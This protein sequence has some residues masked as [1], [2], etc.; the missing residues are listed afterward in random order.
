MRHDGWGQNSVV[1]RKRPCK[2]YGG[3]MGK[4]MFR[5]TGGDH[6][7]SLDEALTSCLRAS[8][9][10][11]VGR[12]SK[13]APH[14]TLV[15]KARGKTN[16]A[17][18][19]GGVWHR[20]LTGDKNELLNTKQDRDPVADKQKRKKEKRAANGRIHRGDRGERLSEVSEAWNKARSM[21]EEGGWE[22]S[23]QRHLWMSTKDRLWI[24]TCPGQEERA[25]H[26]DGDCK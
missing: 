20:G 16:P 23:E 26:T 19:R 11:T 9:R 8:W 15:R 24:R 10:R 6:S 2:T 21:G 22:A 1:S 18:E 7:T 13:D 25:G 3:A 14:R 12:R 5:L 17:S 4:T